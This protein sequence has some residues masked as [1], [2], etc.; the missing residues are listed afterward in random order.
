MAG[1]K[2]KNTVDY[3][4]HYAD[5]GSKTMFIIE[6]RFGHEGYAIWY[7]TL[8]LLASSDNHYIDLRDDTNLLFLISKFKTTEEKI[9]NIYDLLAKLNAIDSHLWKNKIVFSENFVKNIEDAYR[10]RSSDCLH[11]L[12]LCRHLSIKC[13]QKSSKSE[14][15]LA[16]K[17]KLNN[18][19]LNETFDWLD[20]DFE[21]VFYRW[22]DYKKS[23][24]QSYKNDDS[25]K[26][27][28]LK[29]KRIANDSA[30]KAQEIIEQSMANNWAG[31]FELKNEIQK[32][33]ID[34]NG[35][36]NHNR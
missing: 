4:P 19:I 31:I 24:N 36:F 15:K 16:N 12:D 30:F 33:E 2:D 35:D 32:Q 13:E 18:T 8:E 23:K 17:T 34:R 26:A 20:T 3:F 10:R 11:K 25:K 9:N 27:F 14:Q 7:K 1:R 5:A 6:S 28:Y 21:D 29:L 22:M